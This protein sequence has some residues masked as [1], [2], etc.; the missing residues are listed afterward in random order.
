[1]PTLKIGEK[2]A[3]DPRFYSGLFANPVEA[4]AKG[5]AA[6][7]LADPNLA[8]PMEVFKKVLSGEIVTD[9]KTQL[10]GLGQIRLAEIN[11]I[12]QSVANSYNSTPANLAV[13]EI[14]QRQHEQAA[15]I[16]RIAQAYDNGWT[17]TGDPKQEW[18]KRSGPPKSSELQRVVDN[19]TGKNPLFTD[20]EIG[21]IQNVLNVAPKKKIVRKDGT[22]VD[23]DKVRA[24]LTQAVRGGVANASEDYVESKTIGGKEYGKRSD[25]NWYAK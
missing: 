9:L 1:M 12:T 14:M 16:G 5:L 17:W 6:A 18:V 19:Y 20:E 23:P 11:L 4:I 25:G 13:L 15:R 21:N 10:G 8:A 2:M 22:T 7:H 24:E 3:K